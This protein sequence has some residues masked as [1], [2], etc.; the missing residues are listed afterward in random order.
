ML[1]RKMIAFCFISM[2]SLLS[3]SAMAQTTTTFPPVTPSLSTPANGASF[4][5]PD[6]TIGWNNNGTATVYT[7]QVSTDAGFT[8][9][10]MVVNQAV[11]RDTVNNTTSVQVS[12]ASG[13]QYF[14]HVRGG[15]AAQQFS[16][17]SGTWTFTTSIA[18]PNPISPLTGTTVSGIPAIFSWSSV[19]GATK[20]NVDISI[21]DMYKNIIFTDSTLTVNSVSLYP[22]RNMKLYWRVRAGSG[23][24][25]TGYSDTQAINTGTWALDYIQPDLQVKTSTDISYIGDRVYSTKGNNQLRSLS[26]FKGRTATFNLRVRNDSPVDQAFLIIGPGSLNGW[27]VAYYDAITAGN[28]ITM[29]VSGGGWQTQIL[30]SGETKDLRVEMTCPKPSVLSITVYACAVEDITRRDAVT[31]TG[32]SRLGTDGAD[33]LAAPV[34]LTPISNIITPTPVNIS[35]SP[36]IKATSYSLQLSTVAD[37]ATIDKS[38]DNITATRQSVSLANSLS[39]Y[40]RVR[41][42]A[43]SVTSDWSTPAQFRTS[44]GITPPVPTSPAN[45]EADVSTKS[46]YL[47]WVFNNAN[48]VNY[49]YTGTI[50][51]VELADDAGFTQNVISATNYGS[52]RHLVDTL[53]P[54]QSYFWHVNAQNGTGISGWSNTATFVTGKD[55]ADANLQ[56]DVRTPIVTEP[57]TDVDSITISQDVRTGKPG[58]YLI[59]IRNIGNAY[60]TFTVVGDATPDTGWKINYFTPQGRNITRVV[61]STNGFV[62]PKLPAAGSYTIRLEITP[63]S[64]AVDNSIQEASVSV[65]SFANYFLSKKFTASVSKIRAK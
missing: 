28:N 45:N 63:S 43:G 34:A 20:Y 65:S 26:V 40:W 16:G 64:G 44:T 11:N 6:A 54:E 23:A 48:F 3:L 29:Q 17:Y 46:T 53:K 33:I 32:E 35:W 36:V 18:P 60:D 8:T 22:Q 58:V 56:L 47:S 12:L 4:I 31:I 13:T 52:S 14:W 2:L 19:T 5:S 57:Y 55:G 10:G 27:T 1:S 9:T 37:F 51:T 62:T 49:Y 7:L 50:F 61:A 24:N 59:T 39:Y 15:N 21:D 42:F 30:K 41:A 25:W 38:Y